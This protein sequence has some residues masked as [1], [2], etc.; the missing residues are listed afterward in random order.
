MTTGLVA[1]V[2]R[3]GLVAAVVALA[4]AGAAEARN[5]HNSGGILYVTQ[6]IRDK[7]KG[8]MESYTRQMHKAVAELQQGTTEDPADAE[9]L[10]YL[11][12]AYAEIDSFCP[13][14][15]AF[16]GAMEGLAAKGDKKKAE[17][18]KGNRDSYWARL[19]NEGIDAIR[20]AQQA[21]PNYT[22]TPKDEAETTMRGEAEKQY[23]R[24]LTTLGRAACLKP[25]D[26]QTIRNLGSV[27]AFKGEFK[28]AEAVFQEGL[29]AAPNDS[30]LALSLKSVRINTARSLVDAK[31]YD[32]AIAF[33]G[34]LIKTEPNNS[35][36]H[37][38]LAD[39]YFKRATS[40][41]GD[42]RKSD[43]GLAGDAYAKASELKPSD[44]DLPF[45]AGLAYTNAQMWAKAEVQWR[46]TLK[47]RPDDEAALGSLGAVQ[48]EQAKYK[49]AITTLHQAVSLKPQN[50]NLHR[51]L[52][53]VYIK[54]GNNGK[55][56]EE[57]MV[58]LAMDKGQ[59]AADAAATAKAA[60]PETAAGKTLASDGA[61]DQVIAWSADND[62]YETWL[63]WAKK[64]AY[65][66]K[67]GSLVTKSD[68]SAP[69]LTV[70]ASAPK[71]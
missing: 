57:F 41:E 25:G 46:A 24:A 61:P 1:R 11:G 35:D 12:W 19:F 9:A 21:Y 3:G 6:G 16:A 54:A 69:D 7:D 28:S 51:Q 38:S 45:N 55:G 4:A 2:V 60:K 14:G 65:T 53:S 44:P 18:A 67:L 15:K 13:A 31:K 39:A 34:D 56:N 22:D 17:W 36:H 66:F 43:F 58:Y 5:P 40:K 29:K 59:P 37:L 42:A 70:A 50:K 23:Q 68:W 20:T 49:D 62:N 10:G 33:F 26:P 63:Y 8:D 47:V 71:K 52:G 64:R 30:G 32:E 48:A 27:Y